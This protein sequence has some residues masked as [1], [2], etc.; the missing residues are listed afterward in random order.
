MLTKLKEFV[1]IYQDDIILL[2][3]V[4]LISL[5]SFAAGYITAKQQEKEP[6]KFEITNDQF[7][8]TNRIPNF[9]LFK[10]GHWALE[11]GIFS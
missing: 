9:E 1:K 3:G 10:F 4:I 8:M 5:L 6:I 7:P 2:I 11:F